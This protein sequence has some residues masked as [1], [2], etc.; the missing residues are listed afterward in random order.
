[1]G[2][3][4]ADSAA[5]AGGRTGGSQA[6]RSLGHKWPHG[7]VP[8]LRVQLRPGCAGVKGTSLRTP[9]RRGSGR[10]PRVRSGHMGRVRA[11]SAARVGWPHGRVPGCAQPGPQA[12]PRGRGE[13]YD[14][15]LAASPRQPP[16][17]QPSPSKGESGVSLRNPWPGGCAEDPSPQPS[18][19]G[20]G[21]RRGA[22]GRTW[23]GFAMGPQGRGKRR[24][25]KEL[26]PGLSRVVADGVRG[27]APQPSPSPDRQGCRTSAGSGQGARSLGHNSAREGWVAARGSQAERSLGHKPWT[28]GTELRADSA[29]VLDGRVPGCLPE[30]TSPRR[31]ATYGYG[32]V[33]ARMTGGSG[34][35]SYE[36]GGWGMRQAGGA[37]KGTWVKSEWSYGHG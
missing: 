6:A 22:H 19:P 1:M 28:L 27:P 29:E 3:V 24:L 14:F 11:D 34:T 35:R 20:E 7:R 18:P 8:G 21:L 2:R 23:G 36:C 25:T 5:R 13:E 32:A 12:S 10:C 17:P 9:G 33:G 37:G 4:R 26:D 30:A 16:S 15:G 31:P